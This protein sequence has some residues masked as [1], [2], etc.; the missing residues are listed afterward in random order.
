ML[1]TTA[2][3]AASSRQLTSHHQQAGS[4]GDERAESKG[5]YVC[6]HVCMH[7]NEGR[8]VCAHKCIYEEKEGR[9]EAKEQLLIKTLRQNDLLG[10]QHILNKYYIQ[11]LMFLFFLTLDT[12]R[13]D[14]FLS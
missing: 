6:M 3:C 10:S 11:Q 14:S 5:V 13:S 4:E 1:H 9:G 8:E 7:S 12:H 2:P